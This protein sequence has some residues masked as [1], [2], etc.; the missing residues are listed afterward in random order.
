MAEVS[1]RTV[2]TGAAAVSAAVLSPQ[3]APAPPANAAAPPVGKQAP[4]FYRYKVG[5]FEVTAVTDGARTFPLPDTF[6]TNVNKDQVNAALEAAYMPRDKMTIVFTP[7]VVN[8]GSKL[9]VIDTGY[10]PAA[11]AQPNSTS[12][13]FQANLAAAGIDAKAID[14]VII[15]HYHQDHVDGLL[16][17][18][19]KP[20]FPNAEILVPALRTQVLDG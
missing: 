4:G 12:G 1:R 19:G 15:S 11:A 16:A 17:A 13:L 9:V 7:I 20:A 5:S 18:D 10:G 6:V 8:T 14:T 3:F 2:L